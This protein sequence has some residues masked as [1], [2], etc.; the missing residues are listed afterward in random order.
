MLL[1]R[2]LFVVVGVVA[3]LVGSQLPWG[4]VDAGDVTIPLEFFLDMSS[5]GVIIAVLGGVLGVLGLQTGSSFQAI[6]GLTAFVGFLLTAGAVVIVVLIDRAELELDPAFFDVARSDVIVGPGRLD[7]G[8]G[9]NRLDDWRS[10]DRSR[11]GGRCAT[12]SFRRT[13]WGNPPRLV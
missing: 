7:R 8:A 6:G 1:V 5:I 2:G 3:V 4:E 10:H 9:R 12:H 11:T 13:R